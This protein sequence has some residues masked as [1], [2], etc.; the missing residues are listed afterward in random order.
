M[1]NMEISEHES[2]VYNNF[3]TQKNGKGEI[4]DELK[5]QEAN[6]LEG[7]TL[8]GDGMYSM[9]NNIYHSV[10]R[11]MSSTTLKEGLKTSAHLRHAQTTVK[12]FS[13]SAQKS[14]NKGTVL[15]SIIL[16]KEKIE[17][18][19]AIAPSYHKNSNKY[20]DWVKENSHLI[21]MDEKDVDD[22]NRMVESVNSH[23]QAGQLFSYEGLPELSVFF[24]DPVSGVDCKIRID[25]LLPGL[26]YLVDLKSTRDIY[27]FSKEAWNYRMDV[28]A[29]LY[30]KGIEI[31]TGKSYDFVFVA[32][33]N[34]P[35]YVTAVY[36]PDSDFIAYGRKTVEML[37]KKYKTCLELDYFPG[38][39]G[40]NPLRLPGWVKKHEE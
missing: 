40:F 28:Q 37:L 27:N 24:T 7:A 12:P 6:T 10:K 18:L 16:E 38:I 35:P 4:M 39:E 29:G 13:A 11:R 22:V 32:V 8:L 33:E 23:P 1:T 25:Y 21:I 20:K 9:P 19:C 15:H 31:F 26:N 14:I 5:I 3:S 30:L 2:T 17:D 34:T 36:E